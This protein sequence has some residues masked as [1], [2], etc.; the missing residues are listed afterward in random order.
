MIIQGKWFTDGGTYRG[1]VIIDNGG[2]MTVKKADMSGGWN[3]YDNVTV[4]NGGTLNADGSTVIGYKGTLNLERKAIVKSTDRW[5]LRIQGG[6][7]NADDSTITGALC[8]EDQQELKTV[9][10][11]KL[12]VDKFYGGALTL[13]TGT[14]LT[15]KDYMDLSHDGDNEQLVVEKG[16]V[17]NIEEEHS[18]LSHSW[19]L[20][21]PAR[22]LIKSGG[23]VNMQ[24]VSLGQGV[25]IKIEKGGVL[26]L[27]KGFSTTSGREITGSGTVNIKGT[28]VTT[29]GKRT[30]EA[31]ARSLT[32]NHKGDHCYEY[33]YDAAAQEKGY[34][35][36]YCRYCGK[37]QKI[38]IATPTPKPSA[39]AKKGTTFK[40]SGLTYKITKTG[41]GRSVSLTK[42][43]SRAAVSVPSKVT[44]KKRSY[45]V[46]SVAAK[47]FYNN[48]KLTTITIPASVK[49]IG[50]QSFANC[51]KLKKLNGFTKVT[52]V[53]KQA[54]YKCTALTQIGSKASTITLPAVQ[55]LYSG[56]FQNCSKISRITIS[57]KS[58]KTVESKAITGINKKAVIRVPA[59]KLTAYKKIFKTSTGYVKTMKI[60]K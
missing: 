26:N 31:F 4:K 58:L 45:A 20:G 3:W 10:N 47:A 17:L 19:K 24:R 41:T 54:F 6:T 22:I 37:E 21:H 18:I 36:Q 59:S 60:T 32:I 46:T 44:Y 2:S 25:E 50:T 51:T 8:A 39:E 48:R 13:P 11:G 55:K 12:T 9:I 15:V 14:T 57:S 29:T 53:G 5:S 30:N 7:L 52:A 28:E 56:A 38:K 42:G 1:N 49:T 16:A 27:N 40:V 33:Y 43:V 23:T 34:G 35:I